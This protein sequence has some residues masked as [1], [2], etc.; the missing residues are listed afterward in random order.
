[1]SDDL[2]N[3]ARESASEKL[4][5]EW[6]YKVALEVGDSFLGRWRGETTHVGDYGEDA[7]YLFWDRDGV[8]CYV[9]GGR[10]MLDRRIRSA[11]PSQGDTIAIARIEDEV[12]NGRTLH[13]FG[14]AI[15]P[16]HD[17]LPTGEPEV[18]W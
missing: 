7:V 4:D 2:L 16:N 5:D 10:K 9:F 11:M 14:V 6:G 17:P 3:R 8:E 1:M 18:D 12:A 15:E 13:R